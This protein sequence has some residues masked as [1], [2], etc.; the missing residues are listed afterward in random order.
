VFDFGLFPDFFTDNLV[1]R[2]LFAAI[3]GTGAIIKCQFSVK[4]LTT[5]AYLWT[6][7]AI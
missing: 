3:L 2:I 7:S 6:I 5:A 4:W 1:A